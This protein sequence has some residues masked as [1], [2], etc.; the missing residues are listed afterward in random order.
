MRPDGRSELL[1]CRD[2]QRRRR[3]S[4]G[5]WRALILFRL[6]KKLESF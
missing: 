2:A 3:R 5:G 4:T 6:R 1:A